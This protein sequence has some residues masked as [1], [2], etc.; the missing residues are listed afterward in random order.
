[1]EV[2]LFMRIKN[3]GGT[4]DVARLAHQNITIKLLESKADLAQHL[5]R[6]NAAKAKCRYDRDRQKLL[7]VIEASF[8]TMAPFNQ[9]VLEV[10][11]AQILGLKD[12]SRRRRASGLINGQTASSKVVFDV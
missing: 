2:F 1:M 5:L 10:F 3:V 6:F 9:L 11:N 7:A 8:G 4:A 12:A